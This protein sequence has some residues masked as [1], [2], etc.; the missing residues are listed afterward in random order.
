M[1]GVTALEAATGQ[2]YQNWF[3]LVMFL[4]HLILGGLIVVP[5]VVFG[6]VHMRNSY[7]RANRRAV[8]VGYALFATALAL[9]GSGLFLTRIEGLFVVQNPTARSVAYWLHV[10]APLVAGWLFVL[11]RLAG[12]KIR[13]KVGLRWAVVAVVFAGGLLILQAQDPRSWNTAGPESGEQYFFPS[14]ARTSTG[15]FIPERVLDK[16]GVLPGVHADVHETWSNSVHR[17]SS[18]NNPAYLFSVKRDAPG[19][20]G[21][22][23]QRAGVA[24]LRRLPRYRWSFF[25]GAFDDPN[26]DDGERTRRRRRASR[27]RACH[28]ITHVNSGARQRRLHHRGADPL[29]V[30]LLSDNGDPGNGSTSQLVKAK[31]GL[32]QEDVPQAASHQTPEFCGTAATRCTCPRSSTSLQVAAGPEPLRPLPA[33]RACPAMAMTSFYYPPEAET[34]LQR[35]PHADP[36]RVRPVRGGRLCS[37]SRA[38]ARCT[39][40]QFPSAPTPRSRKL[41]GH[42]R[43]RWVNER[44]R[45]FS[46]SDVDARGSSSAVQATAP[47]IDAP[48]HRAASAR[49]VPVLAPGRRRYLLETVIRT[50]EDGT[51]LHPGHRRLERDLARRHGARSG[52]D[53]VIGRSGGHERAKGRVDPWSHFVNAYVL[54]R[55]GNRIDRRNAQDIFV[56]LYKPIRSRPAPPTSCTSRSRGA[57]GRD[58]PVTVDVRLQVP[59]VRHHLHAATSTAATTSTTCRSPRWRSDSDSPSRS[60]TPAVVENPESP[61]VEWQRWNDY[62]IGLLRKGGKSKGELRQAAEAFRR[63]GGARVGRTGR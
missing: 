16:H 5:V 24:I 22:R 40:H 32:P 41:A 58:G 17:F 52:G 2:T 47:T 53:R 46:G 38:C 44:H 1:V 45:E 37:T 4:V 3:Y 13:W 59:Q 23:R 56:P 29:P 18:F 8:K 36:A 54:D 28:A 26:F 12:R 49:E 30:R 43:R 10:L 35:L 31:P 14:L 42:V 11:H 7:Q 48:A 33:Q 51:H 57:A 34:E 39:D 15:D 50:D 63:G 27:A 25:S 62:G 60:V 55:D 21:A 61:I 9:L 19:R 20:H 6:I